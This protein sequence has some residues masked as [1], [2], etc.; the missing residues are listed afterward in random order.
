MTLDPL[1][2]D[3]IL[4]LIVIE[5][6]GLSAWL[7]RRDAKHLIA[8]LACFLLSGALLITALRLSLP[9]SGGVPLLILVLLSLSFPAHIA[10]LWLGWRAIR[11][12]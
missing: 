4:M 9:E 10:A 5:F 3:A 12:S 1:L 8:P 7:S 11:K 2:L 6:L